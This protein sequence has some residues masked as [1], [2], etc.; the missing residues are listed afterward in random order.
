MN[1]LSFCMMALGKPGDT[2]AMESPCYPGSLQ[3]AVS[4]GFKVLELPTH[5]VTG[6]EV[7]ALKKVINKI[8]I[9]LLVPNFN[10]PLGSCMP[11]ENKK[12]VVQLLA[13]HGVP[14]I[15]DDIYGDLYFNGQRPKCCKTFDKEGMVLWC[16]SI[17]KTLAPGYR[18]GW[19]AP[20]KYKEQVQKLKWVHA[21]SSSTINNEAVANFLK[22]GRYD[23]H[24]RKL[25]VNLAEQLSASHSCHCRI[26]SRRY[27]N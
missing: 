3:L 22:S 5:P 19:V 4:L 26:F 12:E 17:S 7:D 8:D 9:C 23:T 16:S 6:I 18:V 2:I 27:Q 15:E 24:L 1:A 25:A 10:T 20:G 13:K 21:V 14:L 11:E